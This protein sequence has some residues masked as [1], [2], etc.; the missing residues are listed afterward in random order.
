MLENDAEYA[1]RGSATLSLQI[2]RFQSMTN[3]VSKV[4][5]GTTNFKG[6]KRKRFLQKV[7]NFGYRKKVKIITH[8][9]RGCRCLCKERCRAHRRWWPLG[10]TW[11]HVFSYRSFPCS[12]HQHWNSVLN[13]DSRG[14]A[15]GGSCSP[16]CSLILSSPPQP[17]GATWAG[18]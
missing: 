12:Q 7:L 2:A 14:E 1:R 11:K 10:D 16:P 6:F 4:C 13:I 5:F 15:R 18:V 17:P 8:K 3:P 9:M